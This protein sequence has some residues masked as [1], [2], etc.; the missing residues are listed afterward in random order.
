MPLL[1][2]ERADLANDDDIV[3]AEEGRILTRLHRSRERS[4][5]LVEQRKLKALKEFGRLRC[6]VCLFDFEES[7]GIRGKGFI[8]A[9]H[10]KPVETL[11]EGAKTRLED[12]VL[13]CANC[14]RMVHASRPWLTI[15]QLRD[16]LN[17]S[18]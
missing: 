14:H 2:H 13:L 18:R 5:K 12:L 6:E 16:L 4:R 17:G 8:E 9:H 15:E 10:T 11:V 1:A 3:E 7:Y